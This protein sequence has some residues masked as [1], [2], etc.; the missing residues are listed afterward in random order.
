MI[1]YWIKILRLDDT[2]LVKKIY[3]MLKNDANSGINY[4]GLNWAYHVKILLESLGFYES[5]MHQDIG[6]IGYILVRQRIYD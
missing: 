2:K 3:C 6:S 1:R 5:R 4:N